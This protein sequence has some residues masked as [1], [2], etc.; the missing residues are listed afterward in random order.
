MTTFEGRSLGYMYFDLD[1]YNN[2]CVF[3][4]EFKKIMFSI[5][6]SEEFMNIGFIL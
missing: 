5:S 1:H 6:A 4:Y 3:A 2:F